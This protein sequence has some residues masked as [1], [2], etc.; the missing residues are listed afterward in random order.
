M[1]GEGVYY[2][3]M[4][5]VESWRRNVSRLIIVR[6]GKVSAT[7]RSQKGTRETRIIT[8]QNSHPQKKTHLLA[9]ARLGVVSMHG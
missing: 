2:G 4:Y 3:A 8:T 9:Q 6:D 1:R 7:C 5:I